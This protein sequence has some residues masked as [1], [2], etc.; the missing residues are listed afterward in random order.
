MH[1]HICSSVRYTVF[2]V[3]FTT[4]LPDLRLELATTN[5]L[6][7]QLDWRLIQKDVEAILYKP[8]YPGNVSKMCLQQ[9]QVYYGVEMLDF[10]MKEPRELELLTDSLP[11]NRRVSTFRDRCCI[12]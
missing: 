7:A 12:M 1:E 6:G 9:V 3:T 8:L 5:Y 2:Y 11:D 4:A 10:V